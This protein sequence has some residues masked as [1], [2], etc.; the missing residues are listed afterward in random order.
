M[1]ALLERP[2]MTRAMYEALKRHIMREREK[3]KQEQEQDAM[4][5]RLKKERELK[6]KK[7]EEDSLTLEE[8]NEQ[9]AQL[10]KKLEILKGQKHELFSQLKKVLHQED[11]TRRRAQQKEQNE[12]T[13]SQPT[14]QHPAQA[15]VPQPMMMHGRPALYKPT[16]NIVVAQ[17]LKRT[18]S[19]SPP[20][21]SA[22]F[23]G[24]GHSEAK[25][26]HTADSK[27]S[28]S[29]V[30]YT[31]HSDTK[32]AH[33]DPKYLS[34][35]T[36]AK[37][38]PAHN[39]Y[40][41]QHPSTAEFKSSVYP[42]PGTSH[43]YSA[44]QTFPQ[45]QAVA[46]ATGSYPSGQSSASKYPGPGQ[47]AFTSY[48]SAFAQSHP[49]KALPEPF[50]SAYPIQRMQQPNYHAQLQLE[51]AAQK[52]GQ[53]SQIRGIVAANP[54]LSQ[55]MQLQQQQQQQQQAKSA[56]PFVP[57]YTARSQAAP[58]PVNYPTSTSASTYSNQTSSQGR[59]AYGGQT[60][61]RYY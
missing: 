23:P 59:S 22:T 34:S 51:H 58:P 3:K 36:A 5:E 20:S 39:L 17:N 18:R 40:S 13:I 38:G 16:S 52:Q 15:A 26:P 4:M 60:H 14:Y 57:G 9:I 24:Y 28:H 37:T 33:A 53:I 29:D 32:F 2:K 47:S 44:S 41:A 11:E 6:K 30:K 27:Y 31:S 10:E 50:S 19:P 55:A 35:Y 1:P 25:Y 43:L 7:E 8:T 42:Q 48:P 12:M 54:T 21:S 45:Q 56:A 46:A 49:Q 61:G